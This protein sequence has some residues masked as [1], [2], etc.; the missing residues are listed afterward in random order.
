MCICWILKCWLL[1]MQG[2]T[3]KFILLHTSFCILKFMLPASRTNFVEVACATEDFGQACYGVF[4][5]C[6]S[7]YF[8]FVFPKIW[9]SKNMGFLERWIFPHSFIFPQFFSLCVSS[10]CSLW[11][12]SP[13]S[14]GFVQV[15][16]SCV[17]A[18][19]LFLVFSM[20]RQRRQLDIS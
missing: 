20:S 15:D 17:L 6:P 1:L 4:G 14:D 16:S 10:I 12:V 18:T 11:S 3:M 19:A 5:V 7:I 8:S 13:S 2:V 9:V